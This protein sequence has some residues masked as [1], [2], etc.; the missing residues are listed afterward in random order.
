MF[1]GEG[2]G[3][4]PLLLRDILAS[5]AWSSAEIH[6]GSAAEQIPLTSRGNLEKLATAL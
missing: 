4:A 3:S 2:E 1:E 6:A 5:R